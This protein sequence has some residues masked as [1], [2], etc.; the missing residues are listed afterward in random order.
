MH[1][2]TGIAELK[3][4]WTRM[5]YD[6]T[7]AAQFRVGGPR[8]DVSRDLENKA[9]RDF[10]IVYKY[11]P[12]DSCLLKR[13]RCLTGAGWRRLLQFTTTAEH[14]GRFRF[15]NIARVGFNP[16]DTMFGQ[17]GMYQEDTCLNEYEHASFANY[18]VDGIDGEPFAIC[19]HDT[20]RTANHEYS[21]VAT[22]YDRCDW[23]G[24]SAGW[25]YQ[26]PKGSPCNWVDITTVSTSGTHNFGSVINPNELICEGIPELTTRPRKQIFGDSFIDTNGRLVRKPN[27]TLISEFAANNAISRRIKPRARQSAVTSKCAKGFARPL[28]FL[29]DC[30]WRVM[31]EAL[32][33]QPGKNTLIMVQVDKLGMNPTQ[34]S[35]LP[36][37]AVRVCESS[38]ALGNISTRCEYVDALAH[39]VVPAKGIV[40]VYFRCPAARDAIE[41]GGLFSVLAAKYAAFEV[42]DLIVPNITVTTF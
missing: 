34:I 11:I 5:A 10:N 33:C 15:L 36:T 8:G 16:N 38:R 31:K 4:H 30:G 27:C 3:M 21:P 17:M 20:I 24:I 18:R 35:A 41:T 22:Q 1:H 28:S 7:I 2:Q 12:A 39:G 14:V 40:P 29:R 25:S 13:D 26:I 32:T 9:P 42:L 6:E 23:Q 37:V 19:L